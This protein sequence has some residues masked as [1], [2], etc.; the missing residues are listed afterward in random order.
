ML[1]AIFFDMDETL[2]GTSVADEQASQKFSDWIKQTYPHIVD[3]QRFS[4]RYLAGVYKQLNHE[5]PQLAALLPD[6]AHFRCELI[7]TL[8][9]EQGIHVDEPAARVALAYFDNERM[10]AFTFFSGVAELL[11]SLRKRYTLVVITNGPRFSQYPKLA[12]VNMADWVDHIIVGGDEPAEK[13][14]ASIFQKALDLAGVPPEQALHIGDSLACD[15]AGAN[16]MGIT[17]VWVDASGKGKLSDVLPNHRV[18]QVTELPEI[19]AKLH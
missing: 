8:L 18:R 13:P 14:A 12:A 17:S 16:A 6:E 1:K 2:C 9:A 5:F 4:K 19:L 11:V 15:I 3:E 10:A 7:R